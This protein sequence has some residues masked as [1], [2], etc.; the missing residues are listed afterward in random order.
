MRGNIESSLAHVTSRKERERLRPACLI[1]ES[2]DCLEQ[3]AAVLLH[4]DRV[5]A[6]GSI[7]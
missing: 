7:T 4:D 2:L 6:L 1:E 5:G 3:N